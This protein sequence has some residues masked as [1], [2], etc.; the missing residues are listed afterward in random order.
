MDSQQ[1]RKRR[2]QGHTCFIRLCSEQTALWGSQFH[3]MTMHWINKARCPPPPHPLPPNLTCVKVPSEGLSCSKDVWRGGGGRDYFQLSQF[4]THHRLLRF[5]LIKDTGP[6]S[7]CTQQIKRNFLWTIKAPLQPFITFR[8]YPW[9]GAALLAAFHVYCVNPRL[10]YSE[11]VTDTP[12]TGAWKKI[13]I[14]CSLT[15]FYFA[16]LHPRSRKTL[17]L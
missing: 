17:V 16:I 1:G 13:W 2:Q 5:I 10:M 4:L 3:F 7:L 6:S 9:E 11:C 12:L 8:S 14:D 15:I